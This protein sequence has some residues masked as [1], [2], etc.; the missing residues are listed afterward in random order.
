[1]DFSRLAEL[2]MPCLREIGALM[3]ISGRHTKTQLIDEIVVRLRKFEEYKKRKV[4]KY[5]RID[6][7]GNSGK[8][9]TTYLVRTK[10]RRDYAMKTFKRGKSVARIQEE[11]RLQQ[12]AYSKGVAPKVVD[13][14]TVAKTIVMEKMDRHL[15]DVIKDQKGNL[16]QTQQKQ[17]LALLDKLDDAKVFHND[18]NLLNYMLKGRDMYL[19]DYGM[20][21]QITPNLIRELKTATPN[22]DIATLGLV[23]KLKELNCPPS[24]YNILKDT[25]TP[26]QK[27]MLNVQ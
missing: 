3:D 1:M 22:K 23:I 12:L 25:L 13:V 11:A 14:N 17:I 2:K 7:L 18:S 27:E 10:G 16:T 8:E 15:Y 6:R 19:I 4:D 9:G 26:A 5:A 24:S 21:R 20:A